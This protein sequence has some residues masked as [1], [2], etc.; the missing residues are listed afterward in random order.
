MSIQLSGLERYQSHQQLGHS[1]EA[2][3]H[4]EKAAATGNGDSTP[5]L[6]DD[7]VSLSDAVAVMEWIAH[8][9]PDLGA[10][11]ANAP[12]SLGRLSDQLLRFDLITLP[13]AGRLMSLAEGY[14]EHNGARS[15]FTR[16]GE[17]LE[18]SEGFQQKQEW[19]RLERL[20]SNLTAAQGRATQ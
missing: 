19:Q 17:Q 9:A 10:P 7:A 4:S 11:S 16:I 8:Q 20:V 5:N 14:D 2:P 3:Q 1:P 13:E 18:Q 12:A 15:L 6:P